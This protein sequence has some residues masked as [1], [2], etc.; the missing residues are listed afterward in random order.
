MKSLKISVIAAAVMLLA[1]GSVSPAHE[2]QMDSRQQPSIT[3]PTHLDRQP[4]A[5]GAGDECGYY[6][7]YDDTATTL[8]GFTIP[9]QYGD[10]LY[11]TRFSVEPSRSCTLA[12]A[13]IALAGGWM[14][15]TPG[16]RV[17]LWADDGSGFPSAKL[18]SVDIPYTLL[19][20]GFGW[21]GADFSAGNHVFSDGEEF[22][23]GWTMIGGSGDTLCGISDLATG[24]HTGEERSSVYYNGA[25]Y[26]MYQLWSNDYAFLIEAELC[27]GSPPSGGVTVSLSGSGAGAGN[28]IIAGLPVTF[29]VHFYNNSGTSITGSTNGFRVYSPDA[30]TWDVPTY[31]STG[32]LEPYYNLGVF[33]NEFSLDGSNDDTIGIGGCIMTGTGLPSGFDED[34]LTISTQVSNS[35]LGK[36][37]CVDSTWYPPSNSWRWA[38]VGGSLEPDWGGPYCH[39]IVEGCLTEADAFGLGHDALGSSCLEVLTDRL[40]AVQ[41]APDYSGGVAIDLGGVIGWDAEFLAEPH[42]EPLIELGAAAYGP[43]GSQTGQFL[44]SWK[45]V[46]DGANSRFVVQFEENVQSYRME[47]LAGGQVVY[48]VDEIIDTIP[49]IVQVPTTK[50]YYPPE[51]AHLCNTYNPYGPNLD[52]RVVQKCTWAE[53]LREFELF[54]SIVVFAD[55]IRFIPEDPIGGGD[56][57]GPPEFDFVELRVAGFDTLDIFNE[58]VIT[59]CTAQLEVLDHLHRSLGPVCLDS[60]GGALM[61]STEAPEYLGGVAIELDSALSLDILCG[62]IPMPQPPGSRIG[63]VAM[64]GAQGGGPEKAGSVIFHAAADTNYFRVDF[65]GSPYNIEFIH[66]GQVVH[67]LENLTDTI[68]PVYQVTGKEFPQPAD[69]YHVGVDTSQTDGQHDWQ[70]SHKWD[71]IFPEWLADVL[72][73]AEILR[74]VPL[75]LPP[76]LP[77]PPFC[78]PDPWWLEEVHFVVGGLDS[79]EITAEATTP[80]CHDI[81]TAFGLVHQT[82]GWTD[83]EIDGG[84]LLLINQGPHYAGEATV[85]LGGVGRWDAAVAADPNPIPASRL[86]MVTDE[87][88]SVAFLTDDTS[89]YF[90]I[91]LVQPTYTLQ[92]LQDGEVVY[93][94]PGLTDPIPPIRQIPGAAK[95]SE[96]V[97]LPDDI[98][99]G[100]VGYAFTWAFYREIMWQIEQVMNMPGNA[101]RIIPDPWPDP[102]P[103]L[104]HVQV[105][106]EG[107]DTLAVSCES[108]NDIA[109]PE[110]EMFG[111]NHTAIGL[112]SLDTAG[113]NLTVNNGCS[114]Y[115]GS[116][117]VDLGMA[118]SYDAV[119]MADPHPEPANQVRFTVYGEIGGEP[120]VEIAS[121]GYVIEEDTNYLVYRTNAESY[122]MKFYSGDSLVYTSDVIYDSIPPVMQL[123][124]TKGGKEDDPDQAT[125]VHHKQGFE[126]DP[127][128]G[129]F[130]AVVIEEL[131]FAID[132][133]WIYVPGADTIMAD[134][135]RFIPWPPPDYWVWPPPPPP[136]CEPPWC[137]EIVVTDVE[138]LFAGMDQVVI[139][140]E[141]A[142]EGLVWGGLPHYMLG[143]AF[144][145][146]QDSFVV[147]GGI[148]GTGEDGVGIG[149]PY[150]DNFN[151]VTGGYDPGSLPAGAAAQYGLFGTVDGQPSQPLGG[152]FIA[153]YSDSME[154]TVDFGALAPDSIRWLEYSN[155]QPADSG[156]F[157]G[158]SGSKM[159][160]MMSYPEPESM[161]RSITKNPYEICHGIDWHDPNNPGKGP[162]YGLE[163]YGYG[164]GAEAIAMTSC[165]MTGVDL[166]SFTILDES[167][168][169]AGCCVGIRGNVDSDPVNAIDISDLV[170][171]VDYMFTGGPAPACPEE[172]NIDGSCCANPPGESLSDIDIS[173]LVYLVDYMFNGGPPPPACGES[174]VSSPKTAAVDPGCTLEVGTVGGY[175]T[176]VLN[177]DIDI[178]GLQLEL[179]GTGG[180]TMEKLVGDNVDMVFGIHDGAVKLGVLDLDGSEVIPAGRNEIARL[181]GDY[182]VDFALAVDRNI[183]RVVPTIKALLE[184]EQLPDRFALYP[185]Y[186]NPFNPMTEIRFDLPVASTIQLTIYNV[187]GQKVTTLVDGHREAGRRT[188]GWDAS[189]HAS[190]VYFYRLETPTYTN[191]RKMLLLK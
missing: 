151:I 187:L 74:F 157:S 120:D 127:E 156:I 35:H 115:A 63:V 164:V 103:E 113:G 30:A 123:A 176:V 185:N 39:E 160:P 43:V 75:E 140:D 69:R 2:R 71:T 55:E 158:T 125:D 130:V 191:T 167:T 32:A 112:G 72:M 77:C 186:P 10:D 7:Y 137:P 87:I 76:R 139:F 6:Y 90:E 42:P 133:P 114:G 132:E 96:F 24:P 147:I 48:V 119:W 145:D 60:V 168:E 178:R 129:M 73:E 111:L 50:G 44:C 88:G 154:I 92:L 153:F 171:L 149:L 97:N 174:A 172:A 148:G 108:T 155:G 138:L 17:Y 121:V 38:Y 81:M 78:D 53:I 41:G 84:N 131:T 146:P 29:N 95:D 99:C 68:P 52:Y 21:V 109:M 28:T 188:V 19:P 128:A 56:P 54:E 37:L 13:W 98:H 5:K 150:L 26:S 94:M 93:T 190:G 152:Q 105:F 49:P 166:G 135:I 175:T 181:Q 22:H 64:V 3:E 134:L 9:N 33:L 159:I 169:A 23:L 189:R 20:T 58:E 61:L 101:V 183:R 165:M 8:A 173:D 16:V 31:A 46:V 62:L 1:V 102:P 70:I 177:A 136:P 45:F 117:R 161:Y 106:M 122:R 83:L 180:E 27:C 51:D 142:A 36:I 34:V 163:F 65:N 126:Y 57:P 82:G 11:N 91:D 116:V 18:D 80:S 14:A 59:G 182:S 67:T 66:N 47:L 85:H 179:V 12:T 15:G 107:I 118:T 89:G 110:A 25:W 86:G 141:A 79:V 104:A 4:L 100:R 170:Y 40:R 144:I 143:D 184:S 162:S 124:V